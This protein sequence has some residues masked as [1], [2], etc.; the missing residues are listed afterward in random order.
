[1]G[2]RGEHIIIFLNVSQ[3]HTPSRGEKRITPG[4]DGSLIFTS[5]PTNTECSFVK[6]SFSTKS[7][8]INVSTTHFLLGESRRRARMRLSHLEA[9]LNFT[10]SPSSSFQN[11]R[12]KERERDR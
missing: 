2:I 5:C 8:A 4:E 9:L 11:S 12:E 6:E 10:A 1:M 7:D 3:E